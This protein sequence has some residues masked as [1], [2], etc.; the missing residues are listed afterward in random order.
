MCRFKIG[1]IANDR[2]AVS[3]MLQYFVAH[4]VGFRTPRT[5]FSNRKVCVQQQK[6]SE[7]RVTVVGDRFFACKIMSQKQTAATWK[8]ATV[9][10]YAKKTK[11]VRSEPNCICKDII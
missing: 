1:G 10:H 7:L 6:D 3:K 4:E 5:C 11:P 2:P 9:Y 8:I